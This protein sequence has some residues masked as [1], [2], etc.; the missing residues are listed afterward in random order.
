MT[1]EP[2]FTV[3]APELLFDGPGYTRVQSQGWVRNWDL[4]PDGS[5]FIMVSAQG[6]GAG[7][8]LPAVHLVVNW[9]EELKRRMGN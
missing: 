4:H 1:T 7:D 8:V 6:G 3:S 2:A 9:F 5:R